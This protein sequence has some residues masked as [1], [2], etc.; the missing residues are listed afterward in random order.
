MSVAGLLPT[1]AGRKTYR[2]I[3]FVNERLL[4]TALFVSTIFTFIFLYF[5]LPSNVKQ[6]D[7]VDIIQPALNNS[8]DGKRNKPISLVT[9]Y[10]INNDENFEPDDV[11]MKRDTVKNV[12]FFSTFNTS[13]VIKTTNF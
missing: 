2:K 3:C 10:N 4:M 7:I 6:P 13:I 5:N 9:D 1:Y 8:T 11:R 12:L